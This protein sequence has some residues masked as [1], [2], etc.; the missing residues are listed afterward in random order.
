[1]DFILTI[2]DGRSGVWNLWISE[3]ALFENLGF[4]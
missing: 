2:E 3:L 1:M 4:C